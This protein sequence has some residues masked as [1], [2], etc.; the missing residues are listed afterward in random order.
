MKKIEIRTR[1]KTDTQWQK[2]TGS[3]TL[4]MLI[5]SAQWS[6]MKEASSLYQ[7]FNT[8]V[9]DTLLAS[10]HILSIKHLHIRALLKSDDLFTVLMKTLNEEKYNY[11][12]ALWIRELRDFNKLNR[13]GD[14]KDHFPII[15]KLVCAKVDYLQKNPEYHPIYGKTLS[16]FWPFG[17]LRALG[18]ISDPS[19]ILVHRDVHNP[20]YDCCMP[21]IPPLDVIDD[22]K[23]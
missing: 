3:P 1:K 8:C 5:L 19:L 22:N 10:F 21:R 4:Q 15:D 17:D 9:P 23:R 14:I 13:F 6:Y 16:T 2:P 12:R 20:H 11:A 7:Y 18:D